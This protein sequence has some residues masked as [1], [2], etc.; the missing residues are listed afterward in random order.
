MNIWF[1]IWIGTF[2]ILATVI[3]LLWRLM[4]IL[5]EEN[6]AL[7]ALQIKLYQYYQVLLGK[8]NNL[9]NFGAFAE[10]DVYGKFFTILRQSVKELKQYFN[11]VKSVKKTNENKKEAE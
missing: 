11:V 4:S 6:K 3:I 2:A 5:L 9:D 1:Y 8:L 10:H 7:S